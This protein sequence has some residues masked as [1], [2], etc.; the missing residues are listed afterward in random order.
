MLAPPSG[1]APELAA[2][3]VAGEDARVGAAAVAPVIEKKPK[4]FLLVTQLAP[5]LQESHMQQLLEQCGEVHAWRRG[6]APS[7]ELLGF[8]FAQFGDPEAAWKASTCL[9]KR[10]LCGKEIKVLPEE[11]AEALIQQWRASQQMALRVSSDEELEWELERKTVSCKALLDA[12]IEELYGP[13]Q[14]GAGGAVVQ[15]RQ[16]LREKEVARIERVRKRKAWREAE[17]AKTL[18][19]LETAEKRQRKEERERD[20]TDRTEEEAEVRAKVEH[21]LKASRTEVSGGGGAFGGSSVADS[22]AIRD[23]VD[24]VQA[25]PRSELFRTQLDVTVLRND[26]VFEKKL[27][28]WLERKVDFCMGGPQSDLVEYILRRVNAASTPDSLVGDLTRYLDEY[29]EPVVE[30]MWRMLAFELLRSGHS[31]R[32]PAEVNKDGEQLQLTAAGGL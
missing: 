15:R 5:E 31:L 22:R 4:I 28:P 26:K 2:L 8:G 23:L 18:E 16:E 7:G 11:G 6:R 17:F 30:R 9:S 19:R 10:V 13:P 21:E 12:K 24:R 25:E 29:T 32:G 20:D 1:L 3:T 14:D 27:R